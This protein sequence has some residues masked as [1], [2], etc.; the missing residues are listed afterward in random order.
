MFTLNL[1][2][3]ADWYADVAL[4]ALLALVLLGGIIK[5]FSRSTKGLFVSV[6][7]V[8]VSL[9]LTGLTMDP[10]AE[11][12]MGTAISDGLTSASQDWGPAF[13]TPVTVTEDGAYCIMVGD[14]PT[15]LNN[16]NFGFKGLIAGFIADK[17]HVEEGVSV[18]GAA[19]SSITSVCVAAI[20]FLIFAIGFTLVFFVIR[21]IAAPMAKATL[22]GVRFLDRLLGA[23]FSVL[24]GLV[25][26]WVVFAIIAA[27]GEPAAPARDYLAN[28]V[29]AGL[30]YNHNPISTLF[31]SVFGS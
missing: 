10:A 6:F 13:N 4:A 22:P 14:V 12:P 28:S 25:F 19:V 16:D 26:V 1:I 17:F 27:I 24:V 8:C 31:T 5:G 18:A 3:A 11:G 9:L 29:F 7:V 21:R 30:L 15:P 23:L 20:M 2:A